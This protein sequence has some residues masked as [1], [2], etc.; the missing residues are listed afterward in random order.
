MGI[1]VNQTFGKDN[2]FKFTWPGIIFPDNE[3]DIVYHCQCF[4]D[5]D[6]EINF[7]SVI[8]M[9]NTDREMFDEF[10]FHR[11]AIVRNYL[12]MEFGKKYE[13]EFVGFR[14]VGEHHFY[15]VLEAK[16]VNEN[17]F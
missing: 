9:S 3:N 16:E 5:D 13:F 1:L 6:N 2:D 8:L 15:T 10:M 4:W 11:R 7:K 17:E 14:I 12:K